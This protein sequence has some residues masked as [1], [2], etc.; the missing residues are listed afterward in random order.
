MIRT[1]NVVGDLGGYIGIKY[2][3]ETAKERCL[4]PSMVK[5]HRTGGQ[6]PKLC[7]FSLED[8]LSTF[9]VIIL[10]KRKRLVRSLYF[11]I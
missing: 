8:H 3:S 10:I 7:I 2:N 4:A 1:G 6:A 5:P 11:Y 9:L